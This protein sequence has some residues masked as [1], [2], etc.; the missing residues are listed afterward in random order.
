[1]ARSIPPNQAG[2]E[3]RE[4]LDRFALGRD[5]LC[6]ATRGRRA[7]NVAT[8]DCHADGG[9]LGRAVE[10]QGRERSCCHASPCTW[11]TWTERG[12]R[13][14][15]SVH[16]GSSLRFTIPHSHVHREPHPVDVSLI[17]N[18]GGNVAAPELATWRAQPSLVRPKSGPTQ[19]Q[20]SPVAAQLPLT[21]QRDPHVSDSLCFGQ[22]ELDTCHCPVFLFLFLFQKIIY[23]LEIHN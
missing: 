6:S 5:A 8:R 3:E 13:Q 23:S 1:M 10:K 4:E 12:R 17:Q 16:H 11:C 19:A 21:S 20:P 18:P 15:N 2:R 9:V 14:V 22:S 7:T